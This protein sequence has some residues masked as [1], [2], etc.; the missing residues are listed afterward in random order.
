MR[1]VWLA[2]HGFAGAAA[3]CCQTALAAGCE[4]PTPIHFHAGTT[5]A[6]LHGGIP[7][8]IPDCLVLDAR[9]GQHMTVTAE[10][11]DN[12]VVFQI[13]PP[14]W[15]YTRVDNAV[16]VQTPAL[17][18]AAEGSDTSKWSGR[19]DASGSYLIVVNRTQG[20]GE[21]RLHVEIK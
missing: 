17:P 3:V 11:Q 8:G 20:G 15:H 18:G 21:Y 9:S 2:L 16:E 7:A 5:A 6:D 10:S 12:S 19:L 14:P 4:V 13:Y 1:T